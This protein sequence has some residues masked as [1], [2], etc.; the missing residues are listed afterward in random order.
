MAHTHS[1]YDNDTHF[2][3]SHVTRG[4]T[5]EGSLKTLVVQNDHNSE[6]FTFELPRYIE[7]HDML[8]CNR[9]E[10]HYLNVDG[11]TKDTASGVYEVE[12]LQ[13][14]PED[15]NIAILSWLISSHATQ[16]VGSL[17]FCIR[18]ACV[19][20]ETSV[21]EYSWSTIINSNIHVT[22]GINNAE[23]VIQEYADVLEQWKKEVLEEISSS[24]S[25]GGATTWKHLGESETVIIDNQTFTVEDQDGMYGFALSSFI[26]E[27][28]NYD[29]NYIVIFNGEKYEFKL[30]KVE[31]P[32]LMFYIGNASIMNE[33]TGLSFTDTGEP[34]VIY[35][36][37]VGQPELSGGLLLPNNSLSTVTLT[38][39]EVDVKPI[40][41]K[42]LPEHLQF[43]TVV[44]YGEIMSLREL[45]TIDTGQFIAMNDD[46]TEAFNC[47]HLMAGE[48]YT[49]VWNGTTYETLC[50]DMEGSG[51]LGNIGAMT[52]G[53][54]TGEPFIIQVVREGDA[55]VVIAMAMDGAETVTMSLSGQL[56]TVTKMNDKFLPDPFIVELTYDGTI[57]YSTNISSYEII[58]AIRQGL[59]VYALN[60]NE[61]IYMSV[62]TFT[63][64]KVTFIDDSA[65]DSIRVF[66]ITDYV[67]EHYTYTVNEA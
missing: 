51:V 38:I 41:T 59:Q 1:V 21:L 13:E 9:V 27:D 10:V 19:N 29:T 18:F 5:N 15:E 67:V 31:E 49:V 61:G 56:E 50:I 8:L 54:D 52:G 36:M 64:V 11:Q 42:Y 6:R 66:F 23:V 44:E 7:G 14:S 34:F 4:F 45:S 47:P 22:S 30:T 28:T 53:D 16:Y 63:D 24:T 26:K 3:I 65:R 43:G 57:S 40:D 62:S 32:L 60:V 58:N 33:A 35:F 2:V 17:N 55:N 48:T 37:F 20:E 39:S 25:G 46:N 12:D